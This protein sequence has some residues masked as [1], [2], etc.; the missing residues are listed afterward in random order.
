MIFFLNIVMF[1][2]HYKI[3]KMKLIV[4]F[5]CLFSSLL[6]FCQ[7]SD[8]KLVGD[9]IEVIFP[10][11]Q[12]T[13]D[14]SV[15]NLGRFYKSNSISIMWNNQTRANVRNERIGAYINQ[16]GDSLFVLNASTREEKRIKLPFTMRIPISGLYYHNEDSIFIFIEREFV[17]KMEAAGNGEL[18]DFIL[19]NSNG[20][21]LDKYQLDDV[22]FIYNG[23]L[24]PM[25]FYN[26]MSDCGKMISG[27]TLYLPFSIYGPRKTATRLRKNKMNLLCA[28]DLKNKTYKMLPV[29]FPAEDLRKKFNSDVS[30]AHI[31]F[32]IFDTQ[33]IYYSFDHSSAIYKIDPTT[34]KT[35]KVAEFEY[36]PFANKEIT[37][38]SVTFHTNFPA[39]QYAWADKMF[40]RRITIRDYKDFKT[41]YVTQ[42]LDSNL[43]DCGYFFE[44]QDWSGLYVNS[45]GHIVMHDRK[46]GYISYTVDPSET[47]FLSVKQIEAEYLIKNTPGSGSRKISIDKNAVSLNDRVKLYGYSINVHA[48]VKIIFVPTDA[49]CGNCIEFLFNYVNSHED[50]ARAENI[51]IVFHGSSVG[52]IITMLQSAS[53]KQE[54]LYFDIDNQFD[55]FFN[56]DEL[57]GYPM[58]FINED[59]VTVL[60]GDFS[61]VDSNIEMLFGL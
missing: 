36:I 43:N 21:I 38:D 55:Q 4:F 41:F 32:T 61:T 2:T 20:K 19:M 59:S 16:K 31:D 23:Q 54:F 37:S 56:A 24:H 45:C 8:L 27:Q 34:N 35:I 11:K 26:R 15:Y 7:L 53:I 9:S 10:Q 47:K 57:I 3:I 22:P 42:L 14:S 52:N 5:V 40:V 30:M 33:T 1:S 28:Y 60:K 18:D 17:S 6:S 29:R 12:Q 51:K 58:S 48:P 39:P 46:N 13:I 50:Q 44:N 25:I 49:I